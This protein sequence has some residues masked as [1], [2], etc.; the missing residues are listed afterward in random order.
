MSTDVH[1]A[2]SKLIVESVV[3][4]SGLLMNGCSA[5]SETDSI[6]KGCVENDIKKWKIPWVTHG[7]NLSHFL[8]WV[9]HVINLNKTDLKLLMGTN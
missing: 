1:D 8:P 7:I 9:V 2:K 6:A 5:P 3:A 4:D